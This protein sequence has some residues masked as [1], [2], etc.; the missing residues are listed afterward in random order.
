MVGIGVAECVAGTGG[1]C[2]G[3]AYQILWSGYQLDILRMFAILGLITLTGVVPF[4][5]LRALS[6]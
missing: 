3:L 6:H 4:S 2:T 5:G 1:T